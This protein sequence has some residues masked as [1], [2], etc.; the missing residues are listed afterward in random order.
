MSEVKGPGAGLPAE[1][2]GE[3][4]S[5]LFQLLG[6]LGVHPWAG[7]CLPPVSASVSTWLLLCARVSP[8][9]CLTRT[10][11][12]GLGPVPSKRTSIHTLQFISSAE[13]LFP[14]KVLFQEIRIWK[15][16]IKPR[17]GENQIQEKPRAP[18]IS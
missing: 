11:S 16:P 1:A 2:P 9:P 12:L 14:N 8:L 13:T 3:G 6:P 5:R 15:T 10:L 18:G 17:A 7:G 4:P